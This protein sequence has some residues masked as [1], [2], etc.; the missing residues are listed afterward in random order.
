M[1]KRFLS[2]LLVLA[3]ALSLVPA[4][5]AESAVDESEHITIRAITT[6]HPLNINLSDMPVWQEL[7]AKHNMTI[8]WDQVSS[9][10][11]EKKAV[12]LASPDEMPDLWLSGLGSGDLTMN[13][14]AFLDL[15]DLID[16]YAPNIKRMFEEE[17]DTLGISKTTDGMIY[18]LPQVRPFRPNSFAVMMINKT[19]LDK[20]GLPVP[21]NLNELEQALIAFRDK[22]PNG[23]GIQDEIPLDW[24][25]GRGSL[26]PIT[27]LCGAWGQVEDHSGDM[28][29]VKDGK[30]QFLWETEAYKNLQIYLNRL[31]NQNLI[32]I[33]VYTQ[34]YSG[35]MAKSKQGEYP[36]VGVTL[37]WSIMDRTG[38]YSDQ[39]VALDALKASA[40]SDIHPLWPTNPA[41]VVMDVNKASISASTKY[42]E[43]IMALL[44]DIYSEYYSIQMYYGSIPNQVTYDAATDTYVIQDPPAGEY[45]DDV[46]WTNAL[47]DNAPLYFSKALTAK[48]TAPAEETARLDQDAV[49]ADNV[50]AEIYPIVKFDMETTEEIIFL[51]T[52]IYKIVDGKMATWVVDGNVEAEWDA[53]LEQ[54]E[55]MGLSELRQYYQD[56]YD[57]Y[58]GK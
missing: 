48:T 25:A 2:L 7:A 22:D 5:V 58:Y 36:M 35:M 15:T 14:G 38:Q 51:A 11:D 4:A 45:L 47:V 9:G 42:P 32:N 18:S 13:E 43:R 19:W 21:T 23:N 40:D 6:S 10:W 39:Y 1:K 30:V 52:D 41:R 53:Y 56:A 8:E 16:K 55:D 49:Y 29:T 24:S 28:L 12:I 33:E 26:F 31:W 46:K 50:P 17:P 20:V 44:D 57:E 54:L 37:G 34:D 3:M 27:A